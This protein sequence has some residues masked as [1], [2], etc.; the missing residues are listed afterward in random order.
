[1]G[2]IDEEMD[3]D[4]QYD[5]NAAWFSLRRNH[6]LECQSFIA[7]HQKRAFAFFEERVS[8]QSAMRDVCDLWTETHNANLLSSHVMAKAERSC[9]HFVDL[10]LREEVPRVRSRLQDAEATR[11]KREAAVIEAERTDG[12]PTADR[13]D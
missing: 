11:A 8:H 4:M 1:M 3:A 9:T 6:A 12:S 13:D 2:D 10:V 7:E 5:I